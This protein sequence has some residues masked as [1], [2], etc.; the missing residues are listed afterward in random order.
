MKDRL[1]ERI[2]IFTS[3][4]TFFIILFG[5]LG[6]VA[7]AS[8]FAGIKNGARYS[9]DFQY[10][11]AKALASGTDPYDCSLSGKR[12]PMIPGL[13][14][15]YAYYESIGA[16]QRMEA[17]QFPSLLYLL[18]PYTF[19]EASEARI[20]WL[21]SNLI[22]TAVIMVLLK[23]TFLKET[24]D[25]FFA[26]YMLLMIAGLPWRNQIGVGQHTLFSAA[27]FLLAVYLSVEK[28]RPGPA[29]LA[30]SISYFKYTLTV[31]MAVYFIYKKKW[32]EL[33]LSIPL[34]IAGTA[35]A[36]YILHES[37]FD[38]IIKPL[39]VAASLS[40]SGSIDLGALMGG[41]ILSVIVSVLIMIFLM[42]FA[43]MCPEGE[44]N[45]VISVCILWGLV[46][47]YHRL[48][49][50]FILVAVFGYYTV[51]KE[52][53]ADIFCLLTVCTVFFVPRIFN[54][55]AASMIV[56]GVVYYAFTLFMTFLAVRTVREHREG[57]ENG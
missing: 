44:D 24:E 13:N 12:S 51:K 35:A 32:K 30:L 21:I 56:T 29:A 47:T 10:D 25:R 5:M 39:R 37:F 8:L 22:F 27:F 41:G 46:M 52:R 4:R 48:Y 42:I 33:V 2:R 36:A 18:L 49:D 14:D 40:S 55:S 9:Q 3:G 50:F 34:H 20:L 7:F 38:M 54:E 31:P 15:Y 6:L 1:K 57:G 23:L 43:L 53:Y 45:I 17:N 19:F 11:A 28:E 26:I 16:P